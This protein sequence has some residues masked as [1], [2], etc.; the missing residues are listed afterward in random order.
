MTVQEAPRR[1]RPETDSTCPT[2]GAP[3][4]RGQLICLECGSR[5]TLSYRKPPSWRVP[6]AIIGLVMLLAAA[7]AYFGLNA[8]TDDAENE[9]NSKPARLDQAASNSGNTDK[10]S[11][12]KDST[13]NKG[14]KAKPKKK[15][16]AKKKPKPEPAPITTAGGIQSWPRDR[17]GF[18]VVVLSAE[19]RPTARKFAASANKRGARLG[20]IRSDDFKSL[21]T[22]FYIVFSGSYKNRA[23][24]EKAAN[25]LGKRFSGAFPQLVKR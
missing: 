12:D 24:A 18:T 2:C 22:G 16:K 4:E 23:Q 25:K 19:D 7:G 20:V 1:S 17:V 3:A 8:V 15:P 6:V 10:A 11:A 13:P 14:A 9:V 5:I 21:P